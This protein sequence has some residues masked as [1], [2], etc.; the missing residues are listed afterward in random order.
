[1]KISNLWVLLSLPL[2]SYATTRL[3][4]ASPARPAHFAPF[5]Y[6]PLALFWLVTLALRLV[7]STPFTNAALAWGVWAG[8]IAGNQ[9]ALQ[10][11]LVPAHG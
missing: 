5:D 7:T 1:M 9:V 2:L 3:I 8:C 6:R 10:H 4:L 11:V